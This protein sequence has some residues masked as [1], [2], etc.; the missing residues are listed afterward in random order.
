[1]PGGAWWGGAAHLESVDAERGI[2]QVDLQDP[3]KDVLAVVA[4]GRVRASGNG[5]MNLTAS[6]QQIL[7]DRAPA[8][9]VPTTNAAQSGSCFG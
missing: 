9:P 6:G 1:M 2:A 3:V 8:C 4:T 5:Q 7:G